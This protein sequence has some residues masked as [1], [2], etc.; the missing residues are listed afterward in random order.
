MS[1][2][3]VYGPDRQKPKQRIDFRRHIPMFVGIMALCLAVLL[4]FTGAAAGFK[5]FLLPG[6]AA[7]TEA[8]LEAMIAEIQSGESFTDAV[9]AFCVEIVEN[10]GDLR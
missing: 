7:V 4:H 10:A 2:R 5:Q 1:Y 8:A 9:T 6:D 3:I